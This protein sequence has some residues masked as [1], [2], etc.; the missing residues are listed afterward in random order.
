M[1]RITIHIHKLPVR[2]DRSFLRSEPM[3]PGY[4]LIDRAKCLLDRAPVEILTDEILDRRKL[5]K[6]VAETPILAERSYQHIGLVADI[7]LHLAL[8][9]QDLLNILGRFRARSLLV[10]IFVACL[11]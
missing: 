2:A 1:Q 7:R 11:S 6:Y 10:N 8:I 5:L 3:D 4:D 9:I